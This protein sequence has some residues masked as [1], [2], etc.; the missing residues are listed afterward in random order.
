MVGAV[1]VGA[2]GS[3]GFLFPELIT[4]AVAQQLRIAVVNRNWNAD[5]GGCF[6]CCI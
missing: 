2:A 3:G 4:A 1:L 5:S 6:A